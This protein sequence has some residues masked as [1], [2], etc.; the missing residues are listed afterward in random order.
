MSA[1]AG[2]PPESRPKA[3][4]GGSA[5]T[6]S[7][8]ER[9]LPGC[10]FLRSRD[11]GWSSAY[12]SRDLRC[13]AV[14]P[15]A[16]PTVGKQRQL[17][18]TASHATCATFEAAVASDAPLSRDADG[19]NLWPDASPVPV[20]LESVRAR[21]GGGFGAPRTGGQA[22][23]VGLMVVALAVLLVAHA[24]PLAGPGPSASP[25]ASA[26][27]ASAAAGA[28]AAA[29][30]APSA[31]IALTPSPPVA[32]PTATATPAP[33]PKPTASPRTYTVRA[34]DTISGIAA[35]YHSTVKAIVDANNIADPRTIRPGQVLI[36]P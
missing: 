18:V 32:S 9:G 6:R 7:D 35:K 21:S 24:N 2:D 3:A 13:W 4:R 25:P 26:G 29:T 22:L 27:V 31:T 36:I 28:S 11:G 23:L 8:L 12:P 17:C 30:T 33:T 15:V 20:A 1:I 5:K 19:T 10:P 16:Q 34:G 14:R